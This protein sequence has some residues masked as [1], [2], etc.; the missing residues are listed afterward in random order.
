MTPAAT[1]Y[2]RH[3]LQKFERS[4]DDTAEHFSEPGD[5]GPGFASAPYFEKCLVLTQL[6]SFEGSE[7]DYAALVKEYHRITQ[8]LDTFNKE[9]GKEF[10]DRLFSDL[11]TFT[12]RYHAAVCHVYLGQIKPDDACDISRRDLIGELCRELKGDYDIPGIEA[13]ITMLDD[14]LSGDGGPLPECIKEFKG[15][16]FPDSNLSHSDREYPFTEKKT[17]SAH[18]E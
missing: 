11:Q 3:N 10:R 5:P 16:R 13:L 14:N 4:I 7:S 2:I 17:G 8:R 15:A 9:K 12:H 18:S 1:D 6:D